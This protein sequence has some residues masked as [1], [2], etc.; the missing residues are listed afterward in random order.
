[1]ETYEE[2]RMELMRTIQSNLETYL[3]ESTVATLMIENSL[4]IPKGLTIKHGKE[5]KIG[6]TYLVIASEPEDR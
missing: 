3:G 6:R 2:R 1:M 4:S 5:M